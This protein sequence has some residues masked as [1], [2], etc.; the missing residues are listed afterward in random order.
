MEGIGDPSMN[1]TRI[2]GIVLLALLAAGLAPPAARAAAPRTVTT[3]GVPYTWDNSKSITYNIDQ[4]PLGALSNTKAAALVEKAFQQWS[5]IDT[6]KL[7]FE[8]G[9]PLDR[10]VTGANLGDFLSSL[11]SDVNPII[12]DNDGSITEANAGRDVL[13]FGVAYQTT[14]TGR[15]AQDVV[16]INARAVHGLLD[17]D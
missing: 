2:T 1:K 14:P 3:T 5:N 15:I 9:D 16:V 7:T 10:D 12:F 17:P 8:E 4:G 13:A 6:A 11:S